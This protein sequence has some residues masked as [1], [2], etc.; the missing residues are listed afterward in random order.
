M[1]LY[2]LFDLRHILYPY[3]SIFLNFF[4][5]SSIP[6][7]FFYVHITYSLTYVLP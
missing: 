5:T 6:L 1:L 4:E 7:S 2:P 3:I